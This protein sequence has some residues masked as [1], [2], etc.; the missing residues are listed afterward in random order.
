MRLIG[1]LTPKLSLHG[2]ISKTAD[3]IGSNIQPI[4]IYENGIYEVSDGVDGFNPVCVDT[5]EPKEEQE[6]T[7]DI[8]ENGTTEVLPDEGS[9]LSK[10][11]VNVD[12]AGGGEYIEYPLP[13]DDYVYYRYPPCNEERYIYLGVN[14]DVIPSTIEYGTLNANGY[15]KVGTMNGVKDGSYYKFIIP[16]HKD[17]FIIKS[18]VMP[19]YARSNADC[20]EVVCGE[21]A[22]GLNTRANAYTFAAA[23][24]NG[25]KKITVNKSIGPAQMYGMFRTLP[26]K[27]IKFGTVNGTNASYGIFT[28]C[29]FLKEVQFEEM[30]LSNPYDAFRNCV[31]LE[32]IDCSKIVPSGRIDNM[33]NG[34]SSLEILDLSS[35]ATQSSTF[36]NV[37]G[38]FRYC[39]NLKT[40]NLSGW[41]LSH[42]TSVADWFD[43]TTLLED[44]ILDNTTLFSASF[45]VSKCLNLTPKSLTAIFKALPQLPQGTTK[46]LTLHANHKILQSQVDSANAKGW[47][48]AGGTVVSEEEYYG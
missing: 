3:V 17:D 13:Q 8:T 23:T 2:T 48:V 6:K 47:T 39:G 33:F 26:C 44:V 7:V 41:D 36:T 28:D 32:T 46:T 25:L 24:I 4:R 12:V 20:T 34:C 10:V 18:S 27:T 14:G 11:T 5:P 43:G 37:S 16:A 21:S 45:G 40:I 1:K 35:W 30:V 22:Q 9:V 29:M 42:L 38:L 15:T 31:S 19:I